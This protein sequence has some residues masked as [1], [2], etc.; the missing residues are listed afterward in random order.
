MAFIRQESWDELQKASELKCLGR[1]TVENSPNC[2][3][4]G[5]LPYLMLLLQ[6]LK[7]P[8]VFHTEHASWE[9]EADL[10]WVWQTES[11]IE[12]KL[13]VFSKDPLTWWVSP[14]DTECRSVGS[15]GAVPHIP[16]WVGM[17]TADALPPAL[18][19]RACCRTVSGVSREH[20]AQC[21][22]TLLSVTGVV[23]TFLGDRK[24]HKY[25]YA[26]LTGE[27]V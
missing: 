9:R 6:E 18:Q 5:D 16:R 3:P 19:G 17:H 24:G 25:F 27:T 15:P 26:Q 2:N 14:N 12:Y 4:Y 1:P 20:T 13:I 23:Q 21:H 11:F 22:F 10:N 7:S 8:S